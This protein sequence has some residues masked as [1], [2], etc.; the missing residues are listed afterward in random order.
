MKAEIKVNGEKIV[1]QEGIFLSD[2]AGKLKLG[3][4]NILVLLNGELISREK[5]SC[6][7]LKEGNF[8]E[9]ISLVSGG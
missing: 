7:K 6:Y 2:F 8:L 4:K 1:I 3:E 9:F 5:W